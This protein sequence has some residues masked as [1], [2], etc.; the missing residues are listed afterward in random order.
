M[1]VLRAAVALIVGIYLLLLGLLWSMQERLIFPGWSGPSA[2]AVASVPGLEDIRIP[3]GDGSTRSGWW[4]QPDDGAPTLVI[5][6][7]NA[8]TQW[9]RLPA[10]A[11]RGFGILLIPYGGYAGN[12]GAP[13]EPGLMADGMVALAALRAKGVKPEDTILYGESLGTGVAAQMALEPGDWR[14]VVLDAPY[15]SVAQRAAEVHWYFPVDH[16]IRHRF[17]TASIIQDIQAPILILHGTDDRVIPI[18]HGEAVFA[19]AGGRA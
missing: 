2:S 13:S 3:H 5:F 6:H 16:L 11:A 1:K 7:G 9:G 8:G 4:R 18:H 12:P 15:L 19:L 17:D 14:G 10:F